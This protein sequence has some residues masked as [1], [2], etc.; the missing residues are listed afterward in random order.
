MKTALQFI[1]VW[2]TLWLFFLAVMS[3]KSARDRGTLTPVGKVFGLP[4]LWVGL[5]LNVAVNLTLYSLALFELPKRGEWLVSQ[6]T[7]RHFRHGSGYRHAV[8]KF[9][10]VHLLNP[11]ELSGVHV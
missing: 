2:F 10:A 3:L 9:I 5:V 6:R 4:I 1:G 7:K 11:F 8:A